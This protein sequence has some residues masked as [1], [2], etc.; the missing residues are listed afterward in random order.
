M[1][2]LM[3]GLFALM[4]GCSDDITGSCGED[5][6]PS[7]LPVEYACSVIQLCRTGSEDM[8]T[9]FITE[10][11]NSVELNSSI[12]HCLVPELECHW[13][14]PGDNAYDLGLVSAK[15]CETLLSCLGEFGL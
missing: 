4:L 1:R 13:V 5:Y 7:D 2:C 9:P 12:G 6:E 15:D 14:P 3:I 8:S 10:C 11:G